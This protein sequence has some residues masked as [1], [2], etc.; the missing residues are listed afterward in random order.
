VFG[1]VLIG[2]LEEITGGEVKNLGWMSLL[3]IP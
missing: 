3:F 1:V 2:V